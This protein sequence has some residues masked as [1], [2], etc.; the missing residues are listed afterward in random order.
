MK[1]LIKM[2]DFVLEIE[3]KLKIAKYDTEYKLLSDVIIYAN[4][5]KQHLKLWMFIPCDEDGN[6]FEEPTTSDFDNY[7]EKYGNI[8][9][10][11]DIEEYKKALEQ[12]QQAKERVLFYGFN[13]LGN[14]CIFN[15]NVMIHFLN[16]EIKIEEHFE[17]IITK[18]AKTIYTIEDLIPYNITLINYETN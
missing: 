8:L 12:H 15:S 17:E 18:V 5:L 14:E 1:Q 10:S 16:N 13:F 6:V 9:N 3:Q 2:T 7:H 11:E 4:F